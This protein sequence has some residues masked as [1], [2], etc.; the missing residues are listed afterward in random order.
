MFAAIYDNCQDTSSLSSDTKRHIVAKI[1]S[2]PFKGNVSIPI[3]LELNWRFS[4]YEQ[5][6][7]DRKFW[8]T[9]ADESKPDSTQGNEAVIGLS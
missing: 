6:R 8:F 9:M 2:P 4:C 7:D 3:L 5:T 1:K